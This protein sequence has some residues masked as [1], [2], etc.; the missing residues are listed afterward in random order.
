MI[1]EAELARLR[2]LAAT[3]RWRIVTMMGASKVHH[4]GGSLSSVD[5]ITALYFRKMRYD[6]NN[7]RWLERDRFVMSKGHSVPAQYTALAMLGVFPVEELSTLKRLGSRLQGHPAMHTIPG[8][9]A[10]TGALGEGLSYA[11]GIALA[12]RILGLSYR[13]YCLIGDGELQ[14]GQVWEAA[15]TAAKHCLA[16]VTAIIDRNRLKAMDEAACSKQMDPLPE[17]WASFGWAV[18]EIDGHDMAA[19]CNTLDWSDGQSQPSLIIAN[20]VK[21]KGVSFLEGQAGFHNA[22]IDE[23]QYQKAVRELESALAAQGENVR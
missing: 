17:R 12:G 14:E 16:N 6:P 19:I 15:M 4:F 20:T 11:N 10:C 9:E 13:V 7:P 1:T 3:M 5:I 2:H 18:A 23:T 22:A 21:G 8:L